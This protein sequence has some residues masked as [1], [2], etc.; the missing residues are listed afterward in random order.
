M[1]GLMYY[2]HY[3]TL[4]NSK[5]KFVEFYLIVTVAVEH[6]GEN[7]GRKEVGRKWKCIYCIL[8][9][10]NPC[11]WFNSCVI[12]MMLCCFNFR[13]WYGCHC[14]VVFTCTGGINGITVEECDDWQMSYSSVQKCSQKHCCFPVITS[15]KSVSVQSGLWH[16]GFAHVEF[17]I[18]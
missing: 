14:C 8:D 7:K 15:L 3:F 6:M 11:F 18:C 9:L 5:C 10:L 4:L 2:S 13:I 1:D 17:P 12:V 16:W